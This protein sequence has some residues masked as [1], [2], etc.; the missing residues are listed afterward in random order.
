MDIESQALPNPRPKAASNIEQYLASDGQQVDHPHAAR[1][2]LLYTTGNRTG[3][4][5]CTPVTSFVE[6][7]DLIV[8]AS[9]QGSPTHPAWY[10]NL[11]VN[12]RVWVRRKSELFEATATTVDGDER[13]GLWERIVAEA[14]QFADYQAATDRLIP[15]VRLHPD[16]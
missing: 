1:M 14:P 6:G 8:A 10:R 16:A 3:S 9:F 4:V 13:A 12:P 2:I 7:E 11:A 5:R 15:V